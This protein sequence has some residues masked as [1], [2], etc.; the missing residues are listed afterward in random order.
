MSR[1]EGNIFHVVCSIQISYWVPCRMLISHRPAY[2]SVTSYNIQ[3]PVFMW[4]HRI[5]KQEMLWPMYLLNF[6]WNLEA[7]GAFEANLHPFLPSVNSLL[8]IYIYV[9]EIFD[10]NYHSPSV[11]FLGLMMVLR[12]WLVLPYLEKRVFCNC[13][14]LTWSRH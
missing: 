3:N 7:M 13:M 14:C 9:C 5:R 4:L 6:R 11:N 12:I 10:L 2:L 1:V 8:K